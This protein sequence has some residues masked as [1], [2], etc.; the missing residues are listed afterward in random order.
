MSE[1]EILKQIRTRGYVTPQVEAVSPNVRTGTSYASI[2]DP[3]DDKVSRGPNS[4]GT[5]YGPIDAM[6]FDYYA[7][8]NR[9]DVEF[10][11]SQARQA[12]GRVL[13]LGCGTGRIS[14]AL[15]EAGCEVVGV[16]RS[17]AMLDVAKSK[18]A[19]LPSDK[20]SKVRFVEA[21]IVNLDLN[22][23]FDLII[24]PYQALQFVVSLGDL[25]KALKTAHDHLNDG[26]RLIFDFFDPKPE[27]IAANVGPL[28]SLF[29]YGM[30]FK[31]PPTNRRV[32]V[33]DACH[34]I[35]DKQLLLQTFAFDELDADSRVAGR[36]ITTIQM[37]YAYKYE[38][39]LLLETCGFDTE[40][41]YGDFSLTP[42]GAD[43][44]LQLWVARRL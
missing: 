5:T 16:D 19:G 7:L 31:F 41:V 12:G 17:G 11:V 14:C 4:Q 25:R 10:Y 32:V 40:A 18:V 6:Y 28:G 3:I 24:S 38:M 8:G 13:D 30:E 36:A 44:D 22:E 39:M 34:F 9:N 29:R 1:N 21:D 35:T 26:R 42:Y 37:R 2:A 15:A 27:F 43:A 23:K 33:S 20:R